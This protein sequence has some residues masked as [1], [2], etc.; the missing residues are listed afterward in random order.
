MKTIHGPQCACDIDAGPCSINVVN[1][2]VSLN[3]LK[4]LEDVSFQVRCGEVTAIIG[5]NGAGKSTLLK[6][7]LGLVPYTGCLHFC[8]ESKHGGGAP[9]IGYVPQSLDFDRSIP[10]TVVELFAMAARGRPAF[11][12]TTPAVREKAE[13]ALEKVEAAHLL[14]RPLGRLSGGEMQRI[15]FALATDPMPHILIMDEPN[16]GID[17]T[18]EAMVYDLI[19]RM[20]G[21]AELSVIIVSHDLSMVTRFTDHVICL[22]KRVICQGTAED[23]MTPENIKETFGSYIAMYQ[24]R[25]E[26]RIG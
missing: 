1:L 20:R 21:N 19:Q 9:Q 25:D 23:I 14:N 11:L 18:G 7:M 2:G 22:N 3:K 16:A 5:P 4:I 24:H 17:V 13:R 8:R 10:L 6:A 12:K 26:H 15:M